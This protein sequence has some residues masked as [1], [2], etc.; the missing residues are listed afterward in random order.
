VTTGFAAQEDQNWAK[1]KIKQSPLRHEW[2]TIR[3]GDRKLKA[4]LVYPEKRR[5]GTIVLIAHEVFGMSDSTIN[6]AMQIAKMGYVTIAPDF[7]SGHASIGGGSASFKPRAHSDLS[8]E[9]DDDA[10]DS[11]F[12]SW[13]HYAIEMP[14][15]NGK[16][17][18]VGLSWGGGA[19]FR[20]TAG[21][22]VDPSLKATFVFYDV[23]PPVT[24][25]GIFHNAKSPG[26]FPVHRFATPVFGFY[27]SNDNRVMRTLQFTKDAMENAGNRYEP[28]V[29]QDADHGFMRLGN[30]PENTNPA[31]RGAIKA[32]LTR[33]SQELEKL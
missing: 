17:A 28:I 3:S 21:P 10:V 11:D 32:S 23:S 9:L 16:I 30:D 33:L 15:S 18:I 22:H 29:Y 2:V 4:I 26:V 25:Q 1:D 24:T 6:T 5:D 27:A 14:Q 7:L 8:A 20:Y 12:N 13:I 19:S 31:N